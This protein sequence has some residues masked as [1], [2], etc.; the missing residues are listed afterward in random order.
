M[1]TIKPGI[2]NN[3]VCQKGEH[4]HADGKADD[5]KKSPQSDL[6]G[7]GKIDR[8]AAHHLKCP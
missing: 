3:K 6:G 1:Y 8:P 2:T 5:G 4:G 7:L